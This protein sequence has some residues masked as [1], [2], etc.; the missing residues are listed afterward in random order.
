MVALADA[1]VRL[2]TV[3][4]IYDPGVLIDVVAGPYVPGDS[5]VEIIFDIPD[6]L[7]IRPHLIAPPNGSQDRLG[8]PVMIWTPTE[9]AMYYEV[10]VARDID[11]LDRVE[12]L[13]VVDSQVQHGWPFGGTYYW[14]VRAVA[15]TAWSEYSEVWSFTIPPIMP[16]PITTHD[17]EGLARL[18]NQ[19]RE[20]T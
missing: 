15:G 1:V 4:G 7:Q 10:H 12:R 19:F 2:P 14:R 16:A 5:G 18:L 6:R 17:A 11:F 13:D 3:R 8:S 9:E 20:E